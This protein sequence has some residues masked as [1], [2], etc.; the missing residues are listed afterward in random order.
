[1]PVEVEPASD[2]DGDRFV[3]AATSADADAI[4]WLERLS[5]SA[6]E[7]ARGGHALLGERPAVAP[8]WA[9]RIDGRPGSVLVGVVEGVPLGYLAWSYDGKLAHI[10][11]VFVHADAR[12]LGIGD[13]LL[14]AAMTAARGVGATAIEA[15]VLPGDREMKNLYERAGVVARKLVLRGTLN[16]E[17]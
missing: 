5:R 10:E 3:R 17:R 1:V 8:G 12:G 9:S 13:A 6:T 11:H 7:S 14:G 15:E 4:A 2:D 16:D